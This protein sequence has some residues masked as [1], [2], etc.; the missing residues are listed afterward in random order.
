MTGNP[1]IVAVCV[2]TAVV[3]VVCA[4]QTD[5]L[6]DSD[7]QSS[8]TSERANSSIFIFFLNIRHTSDDRRSRMPETRQGCR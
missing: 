8:E 3:R 5:S 2:E 1:P 7:P 4:L 6:I